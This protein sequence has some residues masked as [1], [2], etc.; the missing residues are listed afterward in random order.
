MKKILALLPCTFLLAGCPELGLYGRTD[1]ASPA[2]ARPPQKHALVLTDMNEPGAVEEAAR[3]VTALRSKGWQV[4]SNA[5]STTPAPQLIANLE[6]SANPGD[7]V[8]L[9]IQVHG[10]EPLA[11]FITEGGTESLAFALGAKYFV[12][13]PGRYSVSL[14]EARSHIVATRGVRDGTV[15]DVTAGQMADFAERLTRR[16]IATSVADHS[17]F[18]GSTVRV[19]EDQVPQACA[20]ATASSSTVGLVGTPALSQSIP[21]LFNMNQF[22]RTI[23]EYFHLDPRFHAAGNRLHQSGYAT[24]CSDTMSV[25][26]TMALSA[27]SLDTWWHW[28][29][30][31]ATHVV[32][33]PGRYLSYDTAVAPTSRGPHPDAVTSMGWQQWFFD[34][35]SAFESTLSGE[36]RSRFAVAANNLADTSARGLTAIDDLRK[37]VNDTAIATRTQAGVA[38]T[39]TLDEYMRDG[40]IGGCICMQDSSAV[41]DTAVR[42]QL[43]AFQ[44]ANCGNGRGTLYR[45][46]AIT[47]SVPALAPQASTC[48][49]PRAFRDAAVN[50]FPAVR[51]A[52]TTLNAL[53]QTVSEQGVAVSN[54]LGER[55]LACVSARCFVNPI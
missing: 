12:L 9:D 2:P 45:N 3:M 47:S 15:V 54:I 31:D 48:A 35:K 43:V 24:G 41:S 7:H 14:T 50:Q 25:R 30:L 4:T 8:L 26:E 49:D 46:A 29:R 23:T 33:N 53:E 20:V 44:T 5:G 28:Y 19:V 34:A 10:G 6:R 51:S 55:E 21:R 16:G 1:T 17:C 40:L 18:G 38:T 52:L 22:A 37:V 27:G 39:I 32:R 13:N 11:T 36:Q 42:N